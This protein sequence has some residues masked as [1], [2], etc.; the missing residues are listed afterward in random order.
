M[1]CLPGFLAGPGPDD[2]LHEV[3]VC[4]VVAGRLADPLVALAVEGED[5][6]AVPLLGRLRHRVDVVADKSDR[7]GG[8]DG[9]G[10]GVERCDDLVDHLCKLLLPAEHDVAAPA[11]PW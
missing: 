8:A 9:D 3:V 5:L 10:P 1:T 11:C 4:D 2:L 7:A 6:D